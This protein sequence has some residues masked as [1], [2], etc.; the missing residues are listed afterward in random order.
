MREGLGTSGGASCVARTL[1]DLAGAV[2]ETYGFEATR[3]I[4]EEAITNL[5]ALGRPVVG[6]TCTKRSGC[7]RG[8][9]RTHRDLALAS[10]DA[11]VEAF[12]EVGD[13]FYTNVPLQQLPDAS[14]GGA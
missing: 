5:D 14:R 13:A 6:G 1:V 8:D 7:G 4:F 11:S 10:L 3:P 12:R 9:D 2:F